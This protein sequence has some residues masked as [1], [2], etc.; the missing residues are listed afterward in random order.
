VYRG[1]LLIKV[2]KHSAVICAAVIAFLLLGIVYGNNNAAEAQTPNIAEQVVGSVQ[3]KKEGTDNKQD[4]RKTLGESEDIIESSEEK[5]EQEDE[6][7]NNDEKNVEDDEDKDNI[8]LEF[9]IPIP[10]P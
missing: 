10:F 4:S 2:E 7:K 6:G 8:P 9:E 1:N 3:E 5:Q